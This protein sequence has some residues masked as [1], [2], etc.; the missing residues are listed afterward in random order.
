MITYELA[1]AT[2]RPAVKIIW[3]DGANRPPA[4]LLPGVELLENGALIVGTKGRMYVPGLHNERAVIYG[5]VAVGEPHYEELPG[6]IEEFVRAIR[7]AL[8]PR[9]AL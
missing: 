7:A 2:R 8:R 3:Y 1:P 5:G 6:H 9:P 4:S